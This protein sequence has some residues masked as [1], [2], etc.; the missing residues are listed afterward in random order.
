[1]SL[2]GIKIVLRDIRKDKAMR[3]F[4]G[5]VG[6][7]IS[8]S[9]REFYFDVSD[10]ASPDDILKEAEDWALDFV[11]VRYEEVEYKK[12]EYAEEAKEILRQLNINIDDELSE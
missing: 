10:N 12:P 5:Y 1:V 6:T 7:G 11:T 2:K 8:C 3:R 4:R 9:E